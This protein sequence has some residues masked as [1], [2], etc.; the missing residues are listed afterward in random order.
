MKT[1]TKFTIALTTVT[2]ALLA[3]SCSRFEYKEG[4]DTDGKVFHASFE[5]FE[6]VSKT[7]LDSNRKLLWTTDDRLSIFAGKTSNLQYKYNGEPSREIADFVKVS[8][9]SSG[10]GISANYAVYPYQSTTSIDNSGKISLTL[11]AVQKYAAGSFGPGANTMVAVTNGTSDTYLP[12]KNVCGYLVVK[13]CG[14]GTVS[15]IT[16]TGDNGEKISGEATVTAG[17]GLEPSVAMANSA[18]TSIKLDC[19]PGI[20]LGKTATEFWFCVPPTTFG[21]GFTIRAEDTDGKVMVKYVSSS[22]T[23][24]RN[25]IYSMAA[26]EDEFLDP[27]SVQWEKTLPDVMKTGAQLSIAKAAGKYILFDGT[28]QKSFDPANGSI[29]NFDGID[30]T[31]IAEILND[32]AGNFLA[33]TKTVFNESFDVYVIPAGKALGSTD[34]SL[35][36]HAYFDY[37]GYGLGH[38]TAKGNVLDDGIVTAL[39]GG[40]PIVGAYWEI[41][42]GVASGWKKYGDTDEQVCQPAY[43]EIQVGSAVWSPQYAAFSPVGTT[44]S[45]GF[46]YN[47]YDGTYNFQLISKDGKSQVLGQLGD[48]NSGVSCISVRNWGEKKIGVVNNMSWFPQWGGPSSLIVLDAG[49][50]AAIANVPLSKEGLDG[51]FMESPSTCVLIEQ[52]GKALVIYSADGAQGLLNKIVLQ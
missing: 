7:S 49:N 3:V 27:V 28:T 47:G 30:C 42:D 41:N 14:Q 24:K 19:A 12:F 22:K 16:L 18:A 26:V 43:L 36:I 37:Y 10:S 50:L 1:I 2:A 52:Q 29:S 32:D 45:E 13:L 44:A 8:G 5:K 4:S 11:P 48:G 17:Y 46:L 21:K 23:I 39:I 33:V 15:S 51:T 31:K 6:S 9:T 35:L 34:P 20:A 38:F 40:Q 25:V